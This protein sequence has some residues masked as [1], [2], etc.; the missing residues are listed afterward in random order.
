MDPQESG[1]GNQ[2]PQ[3]TRRAPTRRQACA[4]AA[5][6]GLSVAACG[7]QGQ[8]SPAAQ[9][10]Q[11]I[12]AQI[13]GGAV[14]GYREGGVRVFKG[15]PYAAPPIGPLRWR[16]PQP[17]AAWTGVRN[18]QAFGFDCMQNRVGWD[19]TQ[20]KLPTS[21]DCL[22]LNV[23]APEN[24]ASNGGPKDAKAPVMVWVHGGGY[25]M[26]SGSQPLFDGAALARRGVVVVTFNYRLGRFGFFAHPALT[27]ET[28]G[29]P[30]ANYGFMD[31]IAAL[32]WVK[33]NIAALGGDP[34]KVTIFGQSAGGGSVNQ[35]LLMAPARGLFQRAISQSG[36]GRDLWPLLSADRPGKASA[37]SIGK[38]FAA[39]AG[40]ETADAASLRALP[41][42]KL[43]GKLDLLN[44]EEATY[45]GPVVDA[46]LVTG[47]AAQGF[48]AGRQ[49]KVPLLIGA[50]SDELG[51]I[52]G[53][54]KGMIAGK[55][56]AQIGVAEPDLLAVYGSKA[57]MNADLASDVSFVEPAHAL[58]GLA[59]KSGQPVWLY[60]FGYVAEAKRKD[61]K[62]AP[63][64]GDLGY[65]FDTLATLKDAPAPADQAMARR[66]ADTWTTF[67]KTG[68]P[69]GAGLP[70]WPAY[71]L[72]AD[73]WLAVTNDGA[74]PAKPPARL[75]ALSA[76]RAPK[77]IDATTSKP[78]P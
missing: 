7:A 53:F 73:L 22:T 15:L 8:P 27:A 46:T 43:L 67:A 69:N 61:W 6:A 50:N 49:A 75:G 66:W 78:T 60:S 14:R 34:G 9:P 32:S 77:S 21:E 37:E 39:K 1:E 4:F 63:H 3:L 11:A 45:S 23:W 12:D 17:P 26:G 55:T 24:L 40:L 72:A 25:V 76:L 57:A 2:V 71:D 41:A 28:P 52:P 13:A 58:A 19:D 20:T 18:A 68:D 64:S 29:E 59:A 70:A 5:L 54:L 33:A 36:G 35:L 30:K 31:Q 38:A 47:S 51:I 62:G 65:V 44:Q 16:P 74:G 56:I 48:S 42:A 10:L